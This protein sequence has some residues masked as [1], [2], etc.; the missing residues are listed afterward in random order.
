MTEALS[1]SECPASEDLIVGLLESDSRAWNRF[2]EQYTPIVHQWARSAGLQA[3]DIADVTQEVFGVVARRLHRFRR[4]G[5]EASFH[6]WIC[7]ITKN[8]L[9]Q[10]FQGVQTQPRTIGGTKGI[11]RLELLPDLWDRDS[12]PGQA[13]ESQARESRVRMVEAIKA[14]RNDFQESTWQ[15]F[16]RMAVDKE[17]ASSIANDLNMN[18]RAVR[19]AKFRVLCRLK[20]ELAS[21]AMGNA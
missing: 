7:A 16:W 6:L 11:R 4:N 5:S 19:Q 12:P 8:A 18:A 21:Y 2:A 10:F 15:A 14:I 9:R 20:D 13:R 1:A 3:S 17:T